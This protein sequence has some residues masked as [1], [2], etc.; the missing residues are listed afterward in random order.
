ML[1]PT[2][3]FSTRLGGWTL[4]GNSPHEVESQL[5]TGISPNKARRVLLRQL[6]PLAV[7]AAP[8]SL[9]LNGGVASQLAAATPPTPDGASACGSATR[10]PRPP[11]DFFVA[12]SRQATESPA[13]RM[14]RL[15][16]ER[17]LARLP[18]ELRRVVQS[19]RHT[20]GLSRSSSPVDD[21]LEGDPGSNPANGEQPWP[22]RVGCKGMARPRSARG[23]ATPAPTVDRPLRHPPVVVQEIARSMSAQPPGASRPVAPTPDK[24]EAAETFFGLLGGP[25]D[26]ADDVE[27]RLRAATI[28]LPKEARVSPSESGP[29]A[30]QAGP[31]ARPT[32]VK[33]T[34]NAQQICW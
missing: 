25:L 30:I 12:V 7:D 8:H 24:D 21:V 15:R 17:T 33:A 2:A 5:A 27:A 16:L 14:A 11:P 28:R 31:L 29:E 9:P 34:C 4:R 26:M 13:T 1:N 22:P 20:T 6:S 23:G 32:P 18:A 19:S 3:Q 10:S